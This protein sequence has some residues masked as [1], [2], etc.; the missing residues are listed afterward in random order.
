[1][2]LAILMGSISIVRSLGTLAESRIETRAP[3]PSRPVQ[4][5]V[6]G[7][8]V[9]LKESLELGSAGR[10]LESVDI[11]PADF[12]D[13]VQQIGRLTGDQQRMM[14]FLDYPGIQE[15]LKNPR[16]AKLLN[17]PGVI[18]ASQD[19]DIFVIFSNKAF[20]AAVKD[21]VLA[22]QLRKVDL[23]AALKFALQ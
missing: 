9:M 2:G 23:R 10:L 6:A 17:D 7:G 4:A 1:M 12:Y 14:R 13:L 19:K 15:I 16:V 11:L 18:R 5:R 3:D 21:P 8:L 22:E 20:A